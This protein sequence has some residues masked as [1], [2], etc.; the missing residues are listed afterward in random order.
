[1]LSFGSGRTRIFP[2]RKAKFTSWGSFGTY[3]WHFL[4][5][6]H[7]TICSIL[8]AK[9]AAFWVK[10]NSKTLAFVH[11]CAPSVVWVSSGTTLNW[12]ERKGDPVRLCLAH[13][14]RWIKRA[15]NSSRFRLCGL[16]QKRIG[17]DPRVTV[18][19]AIPVENIENLKMGKMTV[20]CTTTRIGDPCSMLFPAV[21]YCVWLL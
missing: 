20:W 16:E 7:D 3:V 1:M 13:R 14:K 17:Q 10:Q 12:V 21:L 6:M 11:M 15:P 8:N 9:H 5:R 18:P 19:Q 4:N 2:R